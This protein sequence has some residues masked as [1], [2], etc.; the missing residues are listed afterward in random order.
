MVDSQIKREMRELRMR[1]VIR[2]NHDDASKKCSRCSKKFVWLLNVARVCARCS[3]RVC[4]KCCQQ[5][6][7]KRWICSLCFKQLYV[8]LPVYT[9]YMLVYTRCNRK[10]FYKFKNAF[11]ITTLNTICKLII[12]EGKK[13]DHVGNMLSKFSLKITVSL[14]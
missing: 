4:D 13:L 9:V 14:Q 5:L 12:C 8:R 2:G 11:C 3:H 1:G 7:Q 6:P 10:T